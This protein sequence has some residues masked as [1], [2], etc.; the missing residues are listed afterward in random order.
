M[1]IANDHNQMYVKCM[2][3]FTSEKNL[4]TISLEVV[5]FHH[6]IVTIQM[7]PDSQH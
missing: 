6:A 1:R 4:Y 7:V 2:Y 5:R 3:F